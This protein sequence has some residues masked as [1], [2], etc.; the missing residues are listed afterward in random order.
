MGSFRINRTSCNSVL[1]RRLLTP[2]WAIAGTLLRSGVFTV[3]R[4]FGRDAATLHELGSNFI[5][6]FRCIVRGKERLGFTHNRSLCAV[7]RGAG[8]NSGYVAIVFGTN[9]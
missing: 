5:N 1:L 2:S 9:V 8:P 3:A 7:I 4:L 6:F